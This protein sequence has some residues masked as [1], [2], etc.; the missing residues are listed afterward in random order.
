MYYETRK[1]RYK[2]IIFECPNNHKM[3]IEEPKTGTS[4]LI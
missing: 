2:D 4:K 3:E 1:E